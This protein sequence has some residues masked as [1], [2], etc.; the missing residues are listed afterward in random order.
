MRVGNN[1]LRLRD[2]FRRELTPYI[3]NITDSEFTDELAFFIENEK[4]DKLMLDRARRQKG[5]FFR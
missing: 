1:F 2:N 3:G 4:L 5:R